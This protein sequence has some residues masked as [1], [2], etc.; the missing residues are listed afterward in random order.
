MMKSNTLN[1]SGGPGA[2]PET[3]LEQARQAITALPE[4]GIS[5]L[6]MSHRSEWFRSLLIEAEA[7]LRSLLGISDDFAITF[8]Q[9]GS[10]LQFAMIPMNFATAQ[11]APPEYVTSGYWSARAT[12]EAA[13]VTKS[14]VAWDGANVG[15]R[16]LPEL[17]ELDIAGSAAYLHYVSNETVE[18]LQFSECRT[19][20]PVPLVADMSSD[21]LS[22]PFEIDRYSFIYAHAQKNLGPSGVTVAMVKRSLLERIPDGLPVILDY[23]THIKHGSNYNTPPVFAI[24]VLTLVTRWLRADIGGLQAMERINERKSRR[25][26]ET[27]EALG[28]AVKIHADRPWRSQMNV[29]FTFGDARLD[30]AFVEAARERGIVGLEGHRSIGGLR[31]S[32]Y[33]AVTEQAVETLTSALMEFSHERV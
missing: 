11:F 29:A 2:L 9:G 19:S 26:Y 7:N 5:V 32:L 24:Y 14:R 13:R 30:D 21:F 20:M 15:Y 31:V 18:G 33:N 3:V 22:K 23:R 27:L 8:M 28:D 12:S 17:A 4:T 6:G 1:F 16:R 25:L 10:S